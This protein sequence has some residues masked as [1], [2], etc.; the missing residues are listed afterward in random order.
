MVRKSRIELFDN[1]YSNSLLDLGMVLKKVNLYL[2]LKGI[3]LADVFRACDT[4]Y[5]E[6]VG[7]DMYIQFLRK[8]GV[9]LT[10]S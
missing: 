8:V 4:S 6:V 2:S 9:R 10:E 5:V 3:T 7:V 1:V